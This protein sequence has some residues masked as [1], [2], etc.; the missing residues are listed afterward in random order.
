[1]PSKPSP[2]NLHATTKGDELEVRRNNVDDL[3]SLLIFVAD[4]LFHLGVETWPVSSYTVMDKENPSNFFG[5]SS[6]MFNCSALPEGKLP[7]K[8]KDWT[9][10]GDV[11][12][13]VCWRITNH[14]EA[15]GVDV[16]S[17]ADGITYS[18]L[19]NNITNQSTTTNTDTTEYKASTIAVQSFCTNLQPFCS[20]SINSTSSPEDG[21]R[22]AVDCTPERDLNWTWTAF[23]FPGYNPDKVRSIAAENILWPR[24]ANKTFNSS[25]S[26]VLPLSLGLF[27][28]DTLISQYNLSRMIASG[29]MN[30]EDQFFIAKTDPRSNGSLRAV[31]IGAIYGIGTVSEPLSLSADGSGFYFP[32]SFPSSSLA[33]GKTSHFLGFA[34]SCEINFFNV[35]YVFANGSYSI[36]NSTDPPPLAHAAW[37][38]NAYGVEN[39][40]NNGIS[41]P[42]FGQKS[43]VEGLS[44][45]IWDNMT[46]VATANDFRLMLESAVRKTAVVWL[47]KISEP[48]PPLEVQLR[49]DKALPVIRIQKVRLFFLVS[50]CWLYALFGTVIWI[51]ALSIPKKEFETVLGR[52][53]PKEMMNTLQHPPAVENNTPAPSLEDISEGEMTDNG[54]TAS[55]L[56]PGPRTK[57]TSNTAAYEAISLE[58]LHHD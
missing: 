37:A 9:S 14:T 26:A 41:P 46:F 23:G 35:T 15:T 28:D 12:D 17:E 13:P 50:V 36:S 2:S 57:P 45:A 48:A 31:T 3:S 54:S 1:M 42:P 16:Y 47:S 43:V 44:A 22:M 40:G 4:T 29:T 58:D 51:Y 55:L 27:N 20:P 10:G 52:F 6:T 21:R 18:I 49:T 39:N 30:A 34:Y 5:R 8:W 25:L 32:L 19:T 11:E 56:Q 33:Y 24:I 53:S 38:A 7:S